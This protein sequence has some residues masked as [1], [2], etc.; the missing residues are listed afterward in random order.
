[1]VRPRPGEET[2]DLVLYLTDTVRPLPPRGWLIAGGVYLQ[3]HSPTD[4]RCSA[5]E[6]LQ[7][8]K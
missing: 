6:Q 1:M 8:E 4:H 2:R 3:T 5:G 7:Q